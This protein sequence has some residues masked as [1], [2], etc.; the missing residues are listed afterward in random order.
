MDSTHHERLRG[1]AECFQVIEYPVRAT[2]A[3]SRNVL[4]KHKRGPEFADK[5]GILAPETGT[6]TVDTLASASDA[7][8]LAREAAADSVHGN[9]ICL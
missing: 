3:E 7:D 9:S 6:R 2:N 5:P 4:N 1:V 8:V